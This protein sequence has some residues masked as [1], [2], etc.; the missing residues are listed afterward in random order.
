MFSQYINKTLKNFTEEDVDAWDVDLIKIS[1]VNKK[2]KNKQAGEPI[3]PD[4]LH[5]YRDAS[6]QNRR[7]KKAE[8]TEFSD[9]SL[10]QSGSTSADSTTSDA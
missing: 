2:P 6:P 8:I 10:M 1:A 4:E 9:D 5:F 3:L 7:D